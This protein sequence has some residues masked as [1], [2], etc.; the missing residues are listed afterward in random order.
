MASYSKLRSDD[1]RVQEARQ[2]AGRIV[3]ALDDLA[4]LV[5]QAWDNHDHTTLGYESWQAY[6]IAEFGHGDTA[7]KA[8]QIVIAMLRG[9]GL[10]QRAIAAQIGVS[11]GTVN[12]DLADVADVRAIEPTTVTRTPRTATVQRVEQSATIT[13]LDGRTQPATRGGMASAERRVR[14]AER[15]RAR[16]AERRDQSA[17]AA[18]QI[19]EIDRLLAQ[20]S[21]GSEQAVAIR[22]QTVRHPELNEAVAGNLR[23]MITAPEDVVEAEIVDSGEPATRTVEL[24][25]TV[26]VPADVADEA[27]AETI[28]RAL[29]E[30]NGRNYWADWIVGAVTVAERVEQ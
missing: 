8:R 16:R 23:D 14:R 18:A 24:R 30:E 9:T 11:A 21:L 12:N 13:G 22:E 27:V 2:R 3:R 26:T 17:E 10:S 20:S 1:P 6:T 15:D 4:T 19:T 25:L 7:V 28:N 5:Q 29:D